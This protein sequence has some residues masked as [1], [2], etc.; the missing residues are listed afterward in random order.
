M[1]TVAAMTFFAILPV[2]AFGQ[3]ETELDTSE[4]SAIEYT[5]LDQLVFDRA[6]LLTG[7][8][9]E[10][11]FRLIRLE[12]VTKNQ[13][14]QGVEVNIQRQTQKQVGGSIGFAA[15]GSLFGTSASAT[16]RRIRK[17][18]YI[19]LRPADVSQLGTFLNEVV[20]NLGDPPDEYKIWKLSVQEGF[21]LG[22]RY[23]PSRGTRQ[24]TQKRPRW[25]FIVTA[26]DASYELRYQEGIQIIR[27]FGEWGER[28]RE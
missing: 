1:R 20:G 7:E 18:G 13:S 16:Y 22:M 15:V 3:P 6:N 4:A 17:S 26:G 27:K 8:S 9:G 11:A 5:R 21:E 14:L 24:D 23:D 19:F 2:V 28:L 12:S 10:I 25:G